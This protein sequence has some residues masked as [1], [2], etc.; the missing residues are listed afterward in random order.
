MLL[1]YQMLLSSDH[2]NLS[3]IDRTVSKD[4]LVR[5]EGLVKIID[6]VLPARGL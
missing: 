3:L 6:I 4:I 2:R 1:R 5:L